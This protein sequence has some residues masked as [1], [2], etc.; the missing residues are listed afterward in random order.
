MKTKIRFTSNSDKVEAMKTITLFVQHF[1]FITPESQIFYFKTS[2]TL[3][4]L[5]ENSIFA[6][7]F[8]KGLFFYYLL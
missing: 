3:S 5:L 4:F 6:L 1:V 8:K 7:L 2:K